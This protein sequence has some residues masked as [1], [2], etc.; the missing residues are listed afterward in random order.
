MSTNNS[1]WFPVLLFNRIC[2]ICTQ[3]NDFNS[4]Y[5]TQIILFIT[6]HLFATRKWFQILLSQV[7]LSNINNCI[8][9]YSFVCNQLN[10]FKFS[11]R[12]NR[13]N[14]VSYYHSGVT[15]DLVEMK[16][17]ST[18]SEAWSFIIWCSLVAYLG[19]TY[20]SAEVQSACF[21]VSVDRVTRL[22]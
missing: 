6:Y 5:I 4:C 10:G 3:I 14:P 17:Y 9:H 22:G 21:M 20:S 12:L 18:R 19:V 7:P 16:E 1:K 2:S 11:S 13:W 15:V 8:Q